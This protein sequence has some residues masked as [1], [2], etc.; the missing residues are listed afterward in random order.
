[1]KEYGKLLDGNARAR[2]FSGLV[3]DV[4]EFLLDLPL[5]PP[6]GRL[7]LDVTVQDSCHPRMPSASAERRVM[8]WR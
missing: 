8:S 6:P 3:K 1:M 4:H 2:R 7:D 5:K